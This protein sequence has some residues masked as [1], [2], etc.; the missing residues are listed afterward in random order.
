MLEQIQNL[1]NQIVE[2]LSDKEGFS[3]EVSHKGVQLVVTNPNGSTITYD[4]Y[5]LLLYTLAVR[6]MGSDI[7]LN[8]NTSENNEKVFAINT[9]ANM[10]VNAKITEINAEIDHI[11]GDDI[12]GVFIGTQLTDSA[13]PYSVLTMYKNGTWLRYD[14]TFAELIYAIVHDFKLE[15]VEGAYVYKRLRDLANEV[16]QAI[17]E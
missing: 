7:E 4:A 16:R 10:D 9:N 17:A 12:R 13:M 15:E 2:F 8:I 3:T 6:K 11:I 5:E 1:S 14:L